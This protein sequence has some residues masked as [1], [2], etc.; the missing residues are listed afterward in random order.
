[1]AGRRDTG[2]PSPA[3]P[4]PL[5]V[6]GRTEFWILAGRTQGNLLNSGADVLVIPADTGFVM[7]GAVASKVKAAGGAGIAAEVRAHK[8]LSPGDVVITSAGKL[9]AKNLYH[10]VISSWSSRQPGQRAEQKVLQ[11]TLWRAVSRCMSL[12]QLTGMSSLAIPSLGTGT[13]RA[14]R[15]ES[16]STLAAACL[17]GL[18]PD[19]S[20]HRI[21]FC[22]DNRETAE[23]FR[24]AF[25]QQR[26]I[27]QAR[28]L[29][30]QGEGERGQLSANL[31]K[32]WRVMM[33][34]NA[35]V[36]TLA[37]LVRALEQRPAASVINYNIGNIVNSNAVAIGSGAQ[38][39]GTSAG[40]APS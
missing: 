37:A 23:I 19:S 8:P 16:H 6:I 13:G 31:Q 26:L 9:K 29:V 20:L 5:S 3:E 25:L 38:A 2:Q 27:R 34:M 40:R 12:A 17:D 35:D 33:K 24:T 18:Q 7:R 4:A 10:L 32:V 1:M 22:F 14:D 15:F 21:L 36:E 28:E 39:S 30:V 11:A